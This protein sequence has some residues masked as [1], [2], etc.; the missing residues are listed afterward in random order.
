MER[1]CHHTLFGCIEEGNKRTP[2]GLEQMPTVQ[3]GPS[4][5][6]SHPGCHY[7]NAFSQW[8]L[9]AKGV[10]LGVGRK[11]P[12]DSKRRLDGDTGGSLRVGCEVVSDIE[13]CGSIATTSGNRGRLPRRGRFVARVGRDAGDDAPRSYARGDSTRGRERPVSRDP[14]RCQPSL[15]S[16]PVVNGIGRPDPR[17]IRPS[18][19]VL[20]P[21]S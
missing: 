19:T 6:H 16:T 7:S 10:D 14:E 15:R 5:M 4:G 12:A 20:A 21:G 17:A 3:P 2:E 11:P 13:D 8:P 1:F 18:P 9:T